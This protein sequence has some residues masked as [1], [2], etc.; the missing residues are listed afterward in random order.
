[1][2]TDLKKMLRTFVVRDSSPRFVFAPPNCSFREKKGSR[3]FPV[4]R[5]GV[6]RIQVMLALLLLY[7]AVAAQ[8][9]THTVRADQSPNIV[10]ASI[11]VPSPR[12]AHRCV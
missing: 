6:T 2:L 4:L 5:D 10:K 1:L 11:Q 9:D 7:Q 8:E 12:A 3:F